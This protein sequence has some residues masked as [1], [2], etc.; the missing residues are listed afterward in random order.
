MLTA[1]GIETRS[2]IS[3][4]KEIIEEL[5]QYLPLAVLK[6]S[7]ASLC[8][9]ND[10]PNQVATA[11]ITYSMYQLNSIKP[12]SESFWFTRGFCVLVFLNIFIVIYF[13]YLRC[14]Q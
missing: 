9:I 2:L 6:R 3:R 5:Q 12:P 10:M 13:I 7:R 11:L 8:H 14:S 1:C 4:Y